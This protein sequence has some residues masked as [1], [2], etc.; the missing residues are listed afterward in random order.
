MRTSR[1][2]AEQML[3]MIL[4]HAIT[5]GARQHP[6]GAITVQMGVSCG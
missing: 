5:H 2:S 1:F 3:R 6:K 4:E